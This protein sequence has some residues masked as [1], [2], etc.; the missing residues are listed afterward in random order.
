MSILQTIT[1]IVTSAL[2]EASENSTL[3]WVLLSTATRL[4]QTDLIFF[5]PMKRKWP[6]T[7]QNRAKT[8]FEKSPFA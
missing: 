4:C 6:A 3:D 1:L 5:R 2:I 7:L 8:S